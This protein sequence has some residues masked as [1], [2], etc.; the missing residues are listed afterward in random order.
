MDLGGFSFCG[1][2]KTFLKT[3]KEESRDTKSDKKRSEK[4]ADIS[5]CVFFSEECAAERGN[6]KR[7]PT[8]RRGTVFFI[9]IHKCGP[10]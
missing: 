1:Q 10:G 6:A 8:P 3:E 7:A 2:K 9:Y 4:K 5:V